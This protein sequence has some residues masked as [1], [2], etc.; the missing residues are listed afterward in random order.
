MAKK[1]LSILCLLSFSIIFVLAGCG[2]SEPEP[3]V[4]DFSAD[5][6]AQFKSDTYVGRVSCTRQ[7]II[8]IGIDSPETLAGLSVK[9]YNSQ[10]Q[11][12]EDN[13]V[14]SADEAYLPQSSFP[15]IL[16]SVLDAVR[17]G[18]YTIVSADGDEKTYSLITDCGSCMIETEENVIKAASVND[19][20]FNIEFDNVFVTE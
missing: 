13:L 10:M 14:C 18:R 6:T 7:G 2:Q 12:Q 4:V 19:T 17:S 20:E 3:I 16:K 5:F 11:L 1:F 8:T 15:R 9:Y